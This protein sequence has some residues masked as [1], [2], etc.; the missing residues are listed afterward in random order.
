LKDVLSDRHN[1]NDEYETPSF[2]FDPLNEAFHFHVDVCAKLGNNKTCLFYNELSDGLA[3]PWHKGWTDGYDRPAP[4]ACWCNP[5]YS[6]RLR[7][8]WRK[9]ARRA[10]M[11][12]LLCVYYRAD[13]IL[14]H[15]RK[16]YSPM[17]GRSASCGDGSSSWDRKTRPSFRL[18]WSC[19]HLARS[20]W[21]R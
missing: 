15:G 3:Q 4:P 6:L 13:Q 9:H 16:S 2:L 12:V 17:R 19:S 10:C 8:G 14:R 21:S 5:P 18:P 7:H 1:T 11:A 20:W